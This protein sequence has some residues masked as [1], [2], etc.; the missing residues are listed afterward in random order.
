M[1]RVFSALFLRPAPLVCAKEP[2]INRVYC[3]FQKSCWNAQQW[4]VV[5]RGLRASATNRGLEE[6]FPRTDKPVEE[7]ERSGEDG[8]CVCVCV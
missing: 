7:G 6:F 2:L 1:L 3:P 4:S 8:V 5:I